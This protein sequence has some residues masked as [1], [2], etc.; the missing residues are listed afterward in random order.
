[1]TTDNAVASGEKNI[2]STGLHSM[3]AEQSKNLG[4]KGQLNEETSDEDADEE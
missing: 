2:G 3:I 4:F 1:M